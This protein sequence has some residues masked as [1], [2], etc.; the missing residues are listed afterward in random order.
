MK[1]FFLFQR[2]INRNFIKIEF[3][4]Q[5]IPNFESIVPFYEF[6]KKEPLYYN[7]DE[8]L[9]CSFSVKLYLCGCKI[10]IFVL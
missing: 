3:N 4:E 9:I 5:L 2:Q 8:W 10:A 1:T 6:F 7:K